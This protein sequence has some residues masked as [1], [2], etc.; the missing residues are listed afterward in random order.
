MSLVLMVEHDVLEDKIK[1]V[2]RPV[3]RGRMA[4]RA[5]RTCRHQ[6]PIVDLGHPRVLD[7]VALQAARRSDG[8]CRSAPRRHRTRRATTRPGVS[9]KARSTPSPATGH[10]SLGTCA[11][12]MCRKVRGA[13]R[14]ARIVP[15]PSGS[16][17]CFHR[18]PDGAALRPRARRSP[19][20]PFGSLVMPGLNAP[21][22]KV[23]A[24]SWPAR[25]E[26]LRSTSSGPKIS[27]SWTK[28]FILPPE[29]AVRR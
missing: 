14:R 8:L 6:P 19:D 25:G 15:R 3:E 18:V 17:V 24:S 21:S 12:P 28:R 23:S 7:P 10:P 16:R 5:D 9:T 4:L 29:C 2:R 13:R 11:D 26:R 1:P 27:R 22:T 20:S